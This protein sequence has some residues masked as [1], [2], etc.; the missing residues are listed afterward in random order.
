MYVLNPDT[1]QS[2]TT[3]PFSLASFLDL[4]DKLPNTSVSFYLKQKY[5][6]SS[7]LA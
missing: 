6:L 2:N 4:L 3:V 5:D 7:R 1:W